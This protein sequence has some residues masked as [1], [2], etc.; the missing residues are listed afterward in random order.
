M[1]AWPTRFSTECPEWSVRTLCFGWWELGWL[2]VC[3]SSVNC[4]AYS[5]PVTF[6]LVCGISPWSCIFWYLANF[7]VPLMF[8]VYIA[9]S[10]WNSAHKFQPHRHVQTLIS[11]TSSQPYHWILPG[12]PS[13]LQGVDCASRVKA[14]VLYTS[15]FPSLRDDSPECLLC[16]VWRYL[17]HVLSGCFLAI[18]GRS[19]KLVPVSSS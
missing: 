1:K 14:E 10:F 7:Q 19:V 5:F 18:N 2:P 16:D 17:F 12:V 4:S 6:F 13:L 9:S 3:P 15:C 8:L 11:V